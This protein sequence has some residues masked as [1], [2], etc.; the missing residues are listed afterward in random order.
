MR[1]LASGLTHALHYH[2]VSATGD[3]VIPSGGRG[4]YKAAIQRSATEVRS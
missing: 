4:R 1:L 2:G 3:A